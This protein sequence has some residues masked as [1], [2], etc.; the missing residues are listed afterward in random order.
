MNRKLWQIASFDK[1][2]AADIAYEIGCDAMAVYLL[3]SRG[4]TDPFEI[5]SF[6][7]NDEELSDPFLIKDMDKAVAR[8]RR[9]LESEEKIAVYGDYDADGVTATALLFLYLEAL[10]ADVTYY[11]PSRMDEGYGLHNGAVDKLCQ[12]GV[13]LIVTVDNGINS[14][15]ETEYIKSLGM[16]IV[17]TD[18]HQP[19]AVMP[20]ACAVVN[21][22][23][24]DDTSPFKDLA[25]VGVAFKLACALEDGDIFSVLADFADIVAMGTIADIVP[26]KGENRSLVVQGI[27]AINESERVG[28]NALK[29]AA[30]CDDKLLSSANIAFSLAPRINAAGRIETAETALRLLLTED[31]EEAEEIAKH[32]DELNI[33]RQSSEGSIVD[34][35]IAQIESRP[36]I[37]YAKV[38]VVDGYGWH[39]GIIGI[40]AS[41]LVER[42]GKPVLVAARDGSGFAK[43]SARS[44][45]GFSLFDALSNCSEYL[46]KFGGHTL[47]AGFTVADENIEDFRKAINDYAES[48]PIFYPVL[49]IDFKMNP[50][51]IDMDLINSLSLLEP[52]GAENPQPVF[53]I[54]N[55]TLKQVKSIGAT[56]KHIRVT[57]EKKGNIYNAV[58]FGMSIDDFPFEA[59]DVL[60]FAVTIDKN[61]FRGEVKPNIYI[62][63]VRYHEFSD[64]EYF[65]AQAVYNKLMHGDDLSE[66]QR[67]LACPDRAFCMNVFKYIKQ[68]SPCRLTPELIAIKSGHASI[69][70]ARA[71]VILDAF[72]SLGLM[73]Y[74]DGAYS[75]VL[76]A[77]KVSLS[78]ADILKKLH[79]TE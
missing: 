18:H 5:E 68:N 26:L 31:A 50:A 25:G 16:D 61:E 46:T 33:I 53:G 44:I 66:A 56:G 40:V 73:T 71:T 23:R 28:I 42:Y 62:K 24:S 78:D 3:S 20:D 63:A 69:Y 72:C 11:I 76:N 39:S 6:L 49:N 12:M 10:G 13:K 36:D 1:K 67:L 77:P 79:Y 15:S 22:H 55:V 4:M 47:A 7:N 35:A 60:D 74:K 54:Y 17:I 57:F 27:R 8:I 64:E 14:V 9:A 45:D 30:G 2:K 41:K 34:E 51:M 29:R 65:K 38:I 19:G 37:K 48:L 32:L 52:F 21:P 43:G 58:Y 75:V 70:T 59:E